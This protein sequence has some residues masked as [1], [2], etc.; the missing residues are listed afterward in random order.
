VASG[1][2]MAMRRAAFESAALGQSA[3][4][5]RLVEIVDEAAGNGWK[6]VV[7]SSF[8]DVLR[9]VG[10]ALGGRCAG[11]LTGRLDPSSRLAL[12]D[13]F[14]ASPEPLVLVSQIQAGGVGLNI[15]AASVVV[16]TEPQWKPSIEDQAVAR[17][18]RLGQVRPVHV[19]RLLA[20]GGVDQRM[21]EILATKRQ[22]FDEY[23]RMSDLKDAS[24]HAIDV[25]ALAAAPQAEAER[26]II[27]R[28]R[29][30][31]GLVADGAHDDG[32]A[33]PRR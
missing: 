17:L 30:R 25:S 23:M 18:H 24:P 1:N 9:A 3:K 31:L 13:E 10:D 32:R 21:R 28:E 2:F 8:L 29:R 33:A 22:L 26:R 6:T 7:F 16:L 4:L 19:H 12:V 11:L 14:S 27:E 20:E 5:H 15:Q